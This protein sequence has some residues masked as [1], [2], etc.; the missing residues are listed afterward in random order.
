MEVIEAVEVGR[1]NSLSQW[2]RIKV[3]EKAL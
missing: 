3:R 1:V 2:E